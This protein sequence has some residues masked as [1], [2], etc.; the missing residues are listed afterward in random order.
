[1]AIM[2]VDKHVMRDGS[3]HV[4]MSGDIDDQFDGSFI[5]NSAQVGKPVVLHLGGIRVISSVGVRHLDDFVSSFAPRDVSLIHISAAVAAQ[6]VMIKGLCS[7]ARIE[8]AKLPFHCPS[9]GAESL[10]SV[11]W[12]PRAHVDHA[13]KCRCGATMELDGLAEQ[14]LPS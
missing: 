13:P 10:H 1:M 12:R 11:P 2:H 6:I 7:S 3:L 8:S 5:L 14:Y 4:L 9:C